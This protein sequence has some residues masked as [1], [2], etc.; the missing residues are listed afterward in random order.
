MGRTQIEKRWMVPAYVS[1]RRM[2]V[3]TSSEYCSD[4]AGD[5]DVKIFES[6]PGVGRPSQIL[7]RR[8]AR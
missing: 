1:L 3:P 8:A 2:H 7:F 5:A 4:G 6:Q